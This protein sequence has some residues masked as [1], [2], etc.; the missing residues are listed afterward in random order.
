VNFR[1]LEQNLPE[2]AR[3]PN[4]RRA[5]CM[6]RSLTLRIFGPSWGAMGPNGTYK[7]QAVASVCKGGA[8]AWLAGGSRHA[9]FRRDRHRGGDPG[10]AAG[11]RGSQRV[12]LAPDHENFPV[13]ADAAALCAARFGRLPR[14]LGNT[15]R[16]GGSADTPSAF[17]ARKTHSVLDSPPMVLLLPI[18]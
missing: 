16:F 1:Y 13:N 2:I 8:C 9:Y 4:T 18:I 10:Y 12:S 17:L 3:R 6:R 15:G 5:V 7:D 11:Q 14:R